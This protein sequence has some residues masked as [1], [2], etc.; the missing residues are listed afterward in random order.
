V[1]TEQTS[2][3]I[4]EQEYLPARAKIL[5]LAATLDRLDRAEGDVVDAPRRKQLRAAIE[6]L[7]DEESDHAERV[8]LLFSRTYDR[9]W[10]E[11]FK[12]AR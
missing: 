8:Q 2:E 10:R 7:L 4:L 5:E 11:T 3:A 6:L 9:R 12:I 1:N